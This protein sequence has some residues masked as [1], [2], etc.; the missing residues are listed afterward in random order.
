M[1]YQQVAIAWQ[2][3]WNGMVRS[4]ARAVRWRACPA[5]KTCRA[6]SIATSID[7]LLAYRSIT[8]AA[9]MAVSGDQGQVIAGRRP[10]ADQHDGDG[11]SAED[12]GPQAGDRGGA[13]GGGLAVTGHGDLGERDG[14]G[15]LGEGGQPVSLLPGSAASASALRRQPV[16]GS[17]LTQPGC[18]GHLGRQLLQLAPSVGGIGY[19]MY[20]AA[21]YARMTAW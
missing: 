19:H 16:Q 10:V 3:S 6:S 4:T 11:P 13:D 14:A 18:P 15:E 17:V 21:R 12:R 20:E 9:V 5:P 7:H 2:A 1:A 8:C